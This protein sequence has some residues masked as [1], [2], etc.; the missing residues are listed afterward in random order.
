MY[1]KHR[2]YKAVIRIQS[3]LQTLFW[4]RL[5]FNNNNIHV[6]WWAHESVLTLAG[7]RVIHLKLLPSGMWRNAACLNLSTFRKS[8][9]AFRVEKQAALERNCAR[10]SGRQNLYRNWPQF[11]VS[12]FFLPSPCILTLTHKRITV[13]LHPESGDIRYHHDVGKFLLGYKTVLF[14]VSAFVVSSPLYKQNAYYSVL[15]LLCDK[16]D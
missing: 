7:S 8:L 6:N 9:P 4:T 3:L 11:L 2:T 16:K 12:S 13:F 5:F 14:V 10:Y 15:S 1:L